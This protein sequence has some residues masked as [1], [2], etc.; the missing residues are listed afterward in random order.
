MKKEHWSVRTTFKR[1]ARESVLQNFPELAPSERDLEQW[2]EDNADICNE[3]LDSLEQDS[4]SAAD[5]TR[6]YRKQKIAELTGVEGKK[7]QAAFIYDLRNVVR[8]HLLLAVSSA[9]CWLL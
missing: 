5:V 2:M 7:P 6:L 4:L 9:H 1:I 8:P 3:E